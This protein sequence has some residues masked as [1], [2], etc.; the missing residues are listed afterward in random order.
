[1]PC[2][3]LIRAEDCAFRAVSN[4]AMVSAAAVFTGRFER[5][6]VTLFVTVQ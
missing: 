1:M 3:T 6:P 2:S 4:S 5:P